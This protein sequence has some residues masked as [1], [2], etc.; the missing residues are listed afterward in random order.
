MLADYEREERSAG[1]S[2]RNRGQGNHQS[3]NNQTTTT[4]TTKVNGRL[5]PGMI[6]EPLEAQVRSPLSQFAANHLFPRTGAGATLG[7]GVGSYPSFATGLAALASRDDLDVI[8][9]RPETPDALL[10][11]E[12]MIDSARRDGNVGG[13]KLSSSNPTDHHD[14]PAPFRKYV[15]EEDS[16]PVNGN[17]EEEE[18][19]FAT[20]DEIIDP[21]Q[22]D[23]NH[24]GVNGSQGIA[25]PPQSTVDSGSGSGGGVP[26]PSKGGPDSPHDTHRGARFTVDDQR[27]RLVSDAA[28]RALR[29]SRL[30]SR[31][32]GLADLAKAVAAGVGNG[33][34]SFNNLTH[35]RR[36]SL[37]G[38]FYGSSYYGHSGIPGSL[39]SELSPASLSHLTKMLSQTLDRAEVPRRELWT[40]ILIPL[41]VRAVQQVRPNPRRGEA[42]DIRHYIKIKRNPGGSPSDCKFV[43]GFV[44]SKHVATKKM[45]R[46]LPLHNARILVLT[47]SLD[48]FRDVEQY[49]SLES[50]IAQEHEYTRI[51]VARITALRP[52]I[53]V[54]EKTVS[55]LALD[56]LEEAGIVVV[57]NVK[58][59][60]IEA[61][62]RCTQADIVSSID[63][64]S[65]EPRLGRCITFDVENFE[66]V[67]QVDKR[68]NLMRFSGPA[69]DLGCTIL[70]RGGNAGLLHRI[71]AIVALAVFVG[72]N[73]RLEEHLMRDEGA[74]LVFETPQ[75]QHEGRKPEDLSLQSLVSDSEKLKVPNLSPKL[76]ASPKLDENAEF[77]KF[78]E[79]VA[80]SLEP[81]ST[82]LLSASA[83]VR[84]PPP[85]P[86]AKMKEEGEKLLRLKERDEAEET[87]RIIRDE[88]KEVES[89]S[90]SIL[91]DSE[92]MMSISPPSN[93]DGKLKE[94]LEKES[95]SEKVS[96]SSLSRLETDMS[97]SASSETTP[98]PTPTA[99]THQQQSQHHH[100]QP[101]TV[102]HLGG[103]DQDL[104]SILREPSEVARE[105]EYH[106][107][108]ARYSEH[109]KEWQ[110]YLNRKEG[111]VSI[112]PF[113]HQRL[114]ML[115]SKVC[116]ATDKPCTGPA[117]HQVEFYGYGDETLG[118]YLE[119]TC[120]D[121]T[122]ICSA[123]NCDRQNIF[124]YQTYVH[125]QTR[126]QAVLERFVCPVP[127]EENRLL[128]WSYCKACQGA[129]PISLVSQE[130]WSL[131][132]SKYL[133]LHFYPGNVKPSQ[134][135]HDFF[136]DHVRYFAYKNL[137]IRFHSDAINTLEITVP[138]MQL[139]KRPEIEN[140]LKNQEALALARKNTAYWDSVASRI[141]ALGLEVNLVR[142][143]TSKEHAYTSVSEMIKMSEA[144]RR[145]METMILKTYVQ[146]SNFGSLESF[147]WL[148]ESLTWP[149]SISSLF[150][151]CSYRRLVSERS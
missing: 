18:T 28:L 139:F 8:N 112:T 32:G 87:A 81:Y 123:K 135:Q 31:P 95:E 101:A 132:Y 74:S 7:G 138:S 15:A 85:Y 115:S 124:H 4:A 120:D 121:A 96:L 79:K 100:H 20:E 98:I 84:L 149:F 141:K 151:D 64:L 130:T 145:E 75:D 12:E 106:L 46:N 78:K 29:H 109:L 144:D 19:P 34:D 116:T 24:Q 51:L 26:F 5:L 40:S 57:L 66:H 128:M 27:S 49:V 131:S 55:R 11:E 30:K 43:D 82:M 16:T 119:R 133:E 94:N 73:L 104:S 93:L 110:A 143:A 127:G 39:G 65:L 2:R 103:R 142:D 50:L 122:S 108:Q 136:R 35:S 88:R 71:K 10:E 118:Q 21:N 146:V 111:E 148:T 150:S 1:F 102:S 125:H 62:S 25:S 137:A 54:T 3:R 70:V 69:K 44:L 80:D 83:S 90:S 58:P 68:K 117:L 47:F 97:R 134:C 56:M 38:G 45:A 129:T 105:S 52:H 107:A 91:N 53:V 92:K 147:G 61:I 14:G 72:Y 77:L 89:S 17:G 42:I 113:A 41:V 86:L 13:D 140:Q 99:S 76:E 33:D 9:S 59:S 36:D 60:A 22:P 37:L 48:Y 67:T 126:I 23:P 63:R 6:S 114:V